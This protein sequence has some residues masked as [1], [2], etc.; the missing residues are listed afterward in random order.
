MHRRGSWVACL[1]STAELPLATVISDASHYLSLAAAYV[2]GAVGELALDDEAAVA[3]GER[4]GLRLH[5]FKRTSGLPRV[6][7]VLGAL[8]GFGA[9]SLVDVVQPPRDKRMLAEFESALRQDAAFVPASLD[10][11]PD[12]MR[13]VFAV[14]KVNVDD[15]NF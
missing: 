10:R 8:R 5:R 2:R 12:T 4:D 3:R 1:G 6:R 11:R 14:Q 7:A 9:A 15:R 13:V